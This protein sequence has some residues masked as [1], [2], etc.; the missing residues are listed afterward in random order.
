[1]NVNVNINFGLIKIKIKKNKSIK[2]CSLK[3]NI[4]ILKKNNNNSI[5]FVEYLF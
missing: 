2:N 4:K 1:M 5:L 3:K